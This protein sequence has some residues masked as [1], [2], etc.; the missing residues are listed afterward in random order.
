M[1]SGWQTEVHGELITENE[2]E[3][4][5]GPWVEGEQDFP[6]PKG[7]LREVKASKKE[8]GVHSSSMRG[9]GSGSR[10]RGWGVAG[11][12]C[13]GNKGIA[14]RREPRE[15]WPP[16]AQA[17]RLPAPC[18]VARRAATGGTAQW[19]AQQGPPQTRRWAVLSTVLGGGGQ[20]LSGGPKRRALI[21]SSLF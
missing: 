12:P 6:W 10:M 11:S 14:M 3:E 16:W 21:T 1:E 7:L 4:D 2:K 15:K 19:D 5:N 17:L 13:L 9:A 8:N 20:R 18:L